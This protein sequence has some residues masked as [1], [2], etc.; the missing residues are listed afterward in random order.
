VELRVFAGQPRASERTKTGGNPAFLGTVTLFGGH[1]DTDEVPACACDE[2]LK[3][4]HTHD[5]ASHQH[6]RTHITVADAGVIELQLDITD[7]LR[8]HD[9]ESDEVPLKFVAVGGD[10]NALKAEDLTIESIDLELD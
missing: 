9:E 2:C 8:R 6:A 1:A 3:L 4:G 10:G 7:G 5:H